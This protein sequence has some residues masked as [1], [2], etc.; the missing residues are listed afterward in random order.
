MKE[1][2]SVLVEEHEG[3][4]K[5]GET[6][7]KFVNEGWQYSNHILIKSYFK[8]KNPVERHLFSLIMER[9]TKIEE[10]KSNEK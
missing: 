5:I 2:K 4:Y 8:L 1:Y 10:A 6:L 7:N 3:S 9:E